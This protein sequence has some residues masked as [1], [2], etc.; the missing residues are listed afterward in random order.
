MISTNFV[1]KLVKDALEE[2]IG[3]GD[4]TTNAIVPKNARARAVIYARE[5]GIVAGLDAA[6][7]VFRQLDKKSNI[8]KF[9]KDGTKVK[10][11]QSLAQIKGKTKAL[12]T[13]ER[14]ALNFLQHLSGVATLTGKYVDVVK[15]CRVKIFD[16][17]KTIPGMRVLEKYAVKMGGGYN[18][19][20]GLCEMAM[21]KDNH[22][23][24][25]IKCQVSSVRVSMKE[26]I[27]RMRRKMPRGMKIEIETKN[28]KEARAAIESGADI[29]MLD[30]MSVA[31]MKKAVRLVYRASCIVHRK[32]PIIEASGN[33]NLKNVRA[34]A[35]TG[36]D[37]ISVGKLTHSAPALDISMEIE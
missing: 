22:L 37:W 26:I 35:K 36:V 31:M 18:H 19:R 28:L 20:A 25:S 4:L 3:S 34:I 10:R 8:K 23:K 11:N 7:G 5:N 12:L 17:R 1:R 24:H 14:T 30:N 2:D 16:T 32:K 9:V 21:V 15:P 33:V 27:Q 6:A 13:G 29:I